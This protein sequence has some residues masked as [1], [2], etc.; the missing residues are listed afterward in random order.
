M[1]RKAVKLM[2]LSASR[3]T[4][5]PN[6]FS[7][8]LF[9]RI[10]E[11]YLY[12]R[13]PVNIHNISKIGLSPETVDCIV[14]WT[15][16]PE[17]MLSRLKEL[18]SYKYY[19]QF[20]LTGL[21]RDIEKNIP[22]KKDK[23]IPAFI[24]LSSAIGREKVIWRY[25]P[26]LF[27]NTYTPEYHLSAFSQIARALEGYTRSCVIS[28]ADIYSKNR[29]NMELIGAY[30]IKGEQLTDFVKKL[31]DIAQK[32]HM[33]VSSCAEA[34][35]LSGCGVKHGCC[36]D[37]ELIESIV[38]YKINAAKDKNQ[39]RECG[40]IE[41]ID[42]GA[43]NTC[44]NACLYCYANNSVQSVCNNYKKYDGSSPILC[45]SVDACDKISVRSSKPLK[46]YQLSLI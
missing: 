33:S 34:L 44:P 11:G 38:G 5:I 32:N 10:K 26:I 15:K 24:K 45:S 37:K 3:R 6:Y 2:I 17:P 16:N 8:W 28:F 12:V 25:D 42:I 13:N 36:I 1:V 23:I 9:R 21:G 20:T 46:E 35:N 14:F 40:C 4:D 43:Y 22:D 39:R 29:K 41:S 31:S 7:D 19:F 18:D 27:T 30:D